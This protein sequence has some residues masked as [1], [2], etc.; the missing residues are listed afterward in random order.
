MSEYNPEYDVAVMMEA[1]GQEVR[2]TPQLPD[3]ATRL[4]RARLI[5][6]EALETIV[7]GLGVDVICDM[8][9]SRVR[10]ASIHDLRLEI[11]GPGDIVELADGTADLKVVTYGTDNACGIP[12][13]AVFKE[14]MRSNMSK[15][16]GGKVNRDAF[17]KVVKPDSYSPANV[18]KVLGL[19]WEI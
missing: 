1:F 11:G 15:A 9:D 17:G 4:L 16:P 18:R 14:V 7:K 8:G 3:E 13:N 5:L 2:L 19:D 6:E 12:C 10:V